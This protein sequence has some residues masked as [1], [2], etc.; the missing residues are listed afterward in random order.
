MVKKVVN[1][2]YMYAK[3]SYEGVNNKGRKC[4]LPLLFYL[5]TLVHAYKNFYSL[6]FSHT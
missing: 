5:Y 3:A 4:L 1:G 6:V 2:P